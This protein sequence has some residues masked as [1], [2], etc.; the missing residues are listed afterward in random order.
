MFRRAKPKMLPP[1][2]E[3]PVTESVWNQVWERGPEQ[4]TN[5]DPVT[6]DNPKNLSSQAPHGRV[7]AIAPCW[8][9]PNGRIHG[10]LWEANRIEVEPWRAP[11]FA[12]CC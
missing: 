1:L 7:N 5:V 8:R 11:V 6:N 3:E 10:I 2:V 9:Q 4:T 12:E